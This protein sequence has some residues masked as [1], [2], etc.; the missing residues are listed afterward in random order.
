[1]DQDGQSKTV[2]DRFGMGQP[3]T[4]MSYHTAL[5]NREFQL[6]TGPVFS[7][8][9]TA[10]HSSSLNRESLHSP[11]KKRQ[12]NEHTICEDLGHTGTPIRLP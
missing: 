11:P 3:P 9:A 10:H 12:A 1:M 7:C 6:A 5:P 4:C 8:I 2:I